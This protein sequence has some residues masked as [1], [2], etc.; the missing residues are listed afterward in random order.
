VIT[1]YHSLSEVN[2]TSYVVDW[3]EPEKEVFFNVIAMVDDEQVIIPYKTVMLKVPKKEA[4]GGMYA[5]IFF[6]WASLI[7]I[8]IALI[9]FIRARTLKQRLDE[10]IREIQGDDKQNIQ[11]RKPQ[12]FSDFPNEEQ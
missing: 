9:Y 6:A 7:F 12:S 3:L 10:E 5:I 11:Y 2:Q 4:F 8:L 1:V